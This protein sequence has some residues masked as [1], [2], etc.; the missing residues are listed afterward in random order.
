MPQPSRL[1]SP[2]L[3][4]PQ[5][6]CAPAEPDGKGSWHR[7]VLQPARRPSTGEALGGREAL[8][9]LAGVL[10]VAALSILYMCVVLLYMYIIFIYIYIYIIDNNMIDKYK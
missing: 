9:L 2:P 7:Q 8:G 3:G 4:R 10:T 6:A 1:L 5:Q